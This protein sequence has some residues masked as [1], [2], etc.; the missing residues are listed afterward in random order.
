MKS[1]HVNGQYLLRLDRS[2]LMLLISALIDASELNPSDE[3]FK[4]R[5]GWER[6]RVQAFT[7]ELGRLSESVSVD[8][9]LRPSAEEGLRDLCRGG[10]L[11][12]VHLGMDRALVLHAADPEQVHPE[13]T[14]DSADFEDV[15][16]R[17]AGGLLSEIIVRVRAEGIRLP[18]TMSSQNSPR[19]SAVP[20]DDALR[21][22]RDS[23]LTEVPPSSPIPEVAAA[24]ERFEFRQRRGRGCVLF[25]HY[26]VLSEAH[27]FRR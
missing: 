21:V 17:F 9:P 14:E 6:S 11:A 24:V 12:G 27:S 2:E 5:T 1:E 26:G 18:G 25:F 10:W 4:D 3:H 8:P 7:D 23:G 15:S 22:L 13:V 16:F 20:R 19:P